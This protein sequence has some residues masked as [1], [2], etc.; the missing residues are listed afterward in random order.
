MKE[1]MTGSLKHLSNTEKII[2]FAFVIMPNH[3]QLIWRLKALNGKEMTHASIQKFKENSFRIKLEK[4]N[5]PARFYIDEANK[6]Y[7]FWKGDS[8]VVYL[9]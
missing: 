2:V 8:L 1:M 6:K 7:E 5:N 4:T 9:F 3:I